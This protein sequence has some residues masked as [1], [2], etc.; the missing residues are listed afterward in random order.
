MTTGDER[1][2]LRSLFDAAIAAADPAKTIPPA[3]AAAAQGP[4]HRARRRQG[5]GSD[6]EGRRGQLARPALRPRR[7]TLRPRGACRRIEIV[8]AAHPVPDE[9]GSRRRGAH[10]RACPHRRA[11]RPRALPDL[12]RRLGA[13]ALPADGI[14]LADKQAVNRALLASGA[15]I[16]A[17][18]VGPQASLGHQGRTARR[19]RL[20]GADGEPADLRRAR[21]RSRASSRRGRRSPTHHLSPTRAPILARYG[22][23][24]PDAVAARLAAAHRRDAEARRRSGFPA[25]P[26]LIVA[27]PLA[28]LEAAAAAA[29]KAG[30]TPMILGDALEGEAREVGQVDGRHRAVGPPSRPPG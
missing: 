28:S 24:P 3:S 16:G 12:G 29:R 8:E 26:R 22:I 9:T 14:T 10:P 6:G 30:V 21:R 5:F 4:H 2:L 11:G 19:G 25:P 1:A 7:H 18:N 15:D 13:A 27:S 17:M 23:T 20:A